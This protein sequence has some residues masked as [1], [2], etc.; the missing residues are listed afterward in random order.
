VVDTGLWAG[1]TCVTAMDVAAMGM[2]IVPIFEPLEWGRQGLRCALGGMIATA[3]VEGHSTALI[4]SGTT[5][6]ASVESIST[7]TIVGVAT[8]AA[9][10]SLLALVLLL[11][12]VAAPCSTILVVLLW[13]LKHAGRGLVA[14]GVAEHFDLPLH[15]IDGGVVAA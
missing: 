13:I 3:T 7:T 14:D 2:A 8:A 12:T 10:L 1:G 6:I 9:G 15:S 11:A 4:V 5:T